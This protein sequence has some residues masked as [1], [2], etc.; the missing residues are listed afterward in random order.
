MSPR[1]LALAA[2]IAL[3]AVW[4]SEGLGLKLILRDAVELNVVAQSGLYWVSPLA[5]LL[6][7]GALET[8]AGLVLLAGYRPRVAALVTTTA[9]I[10]ITAGVV[11]TAPELLFAPLSGVAKNAALVVCAAVVWTFSPVPCPSSVPRS[12]RSKRTALA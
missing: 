11:G 4:L 7:I 6:T 8:L 9:M 10:A 3:A 12:R 1:R 2:R 5:T